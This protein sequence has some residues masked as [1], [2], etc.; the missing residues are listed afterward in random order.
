MGRYEKKHSVVELGIPVILPMPAKKTVITDTE[1]GK[2]SQGLDW[3]SYKESDLKA[4]KKL[5]IQTD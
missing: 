1:T 4:W 2:Q 3:S 5:R